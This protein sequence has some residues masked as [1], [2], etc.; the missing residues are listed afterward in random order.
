LVEGEVAGE[1]AVVEG[2]QG[3]FEVVGIEA[4]TL[5]EDAGGGAGAET[6]VPHGLNDR[7]DNGAG[8]FFGFF[9]G[10]GEEDIDVGEGE[11]VF[12]SVAAESEQCDFGVGVGTGGAGDFGRK[13]AAP[14][15]DEEAVDDGGAEPSPVRS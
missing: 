2:G 12:A 5:F 3:E 7:L 10:E 4:G 6:D 15:L 8:G 1:E 11:E 13:G 14:K 9:V